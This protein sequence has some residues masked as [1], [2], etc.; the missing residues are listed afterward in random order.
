M[1]KAS[2][3]IKIIREMR[4]SAVQAK[5]ARKRANPDRQYGDGVYERFRTHASERR[6]RL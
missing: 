1:K 5:K 3:D 6:G 2:E 4:V